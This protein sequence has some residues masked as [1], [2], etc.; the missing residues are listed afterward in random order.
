MEKTWKPTAAGILDIVSG[1]FSLIV[2]VALIIGMVVTGSGE[3]STEVPDF[4]PTILLIMAILSLIVGILAL[5]GGV[6]A[7]KREKWGLA[8]AGSIAAIFSTFVLG[9]P[10]I[11]F[12]AQSKNEFE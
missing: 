10:A 11:L 2:V 7:L 3:T 12:T 4:V 6:Y 1:V 8:L 5:V 9:I